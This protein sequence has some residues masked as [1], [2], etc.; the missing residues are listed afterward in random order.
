MSDMQIFVPTKFGNFAVDCF[1]LI[2]KTINGVD[3]IFAL[4]NN[5]PDPGHAATRL[6]LT[7]YQSG[8]RWPMALGEPDGATLGLTSP[9]TPGCEIFKALE[10]RVQNKL[11]RYITAR[12]EE[13]LAKHLLLAQRRHKTNELDF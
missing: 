12:N 7:E 6:E 4:T 8:L 5:L 2:H 3:F 13:E 9:P 11:E 10:A 1:G